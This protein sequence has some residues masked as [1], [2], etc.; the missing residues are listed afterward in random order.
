[1]SVPEAFNENPTT[2]I[3][4]VKLLYE[5]LRTRDFR[6]LKEIVTEDVTWNVTEGFPYTGIYQGLDNVL[7]GFYARLRSNLDSFAAEHVKWIDAGES[8][9]VLGYYLMTPKGTAEES[10]IRFAH[11]WGIRE[12]KIAGVW[13]VADTAKLPR[14]LQQH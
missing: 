9:I 1:M 14:A 12:G 4:L 6:K 7:R 3:E 2:S 5:S 13:Q 11:I 10:R 8:V